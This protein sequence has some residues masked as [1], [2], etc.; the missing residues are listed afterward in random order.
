MCAPY[1]VKVN[2]NIFS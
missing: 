1:F 2:K